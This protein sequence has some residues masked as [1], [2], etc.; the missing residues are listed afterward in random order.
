M[1]SSLVIGCVAGCAGVLGGSA[2][3]AAAHIEVEADAAT[4]PPMGAQDDIGGRDGGKEW[5]VEGDVLRM[6]SLYCVQYIRMV[7]RCVLVW[8]FIGLDCV[9]LV[10]GIFLRLALRHR[11]NRIDTRLTPTST[12]TTP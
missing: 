9:V 6:A 4:S 10:Y 1:D 12:H 5:Y 7:L 8:F 3:A 2:A 11:L